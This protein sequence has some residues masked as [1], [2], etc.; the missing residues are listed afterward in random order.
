MVIR[1][2][3]E[4]VENGGRKL[5]GISLGPNSDKGIAIIERD[6]LDFLIRLGLS[7]SWSTS[8]QGSIV[9]SAHR[10]AGHKVSVARVLLD[11]MP[12]TMI[13]YRDKNPLNLRKDNLELVKGY[14]KRRDRDFLTPPDRK[15]GK[16]NVAA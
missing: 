7:L 6:D 2:T 10:A 13:R 3:I 9:T 14:S 15:Y 1:K 12:G 4:F 16:A 5:V 8:P 11:A